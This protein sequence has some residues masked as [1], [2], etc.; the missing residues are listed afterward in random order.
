MLGFDMRSE[1]RPAFPSR[2][3]VT[4]LDLPNDENSCSETIANIEHLLLP[5]T[6]AGHLDF[7]TTHGKALL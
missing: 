7:P 2:S 1:P 6:A 3:A 4:V 5:G